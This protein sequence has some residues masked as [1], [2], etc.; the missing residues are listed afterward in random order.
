[1]N[2]SNRR[3]QLNDHRPETTRPRELKIAVISLVREPQL[4]GPGFPFTFTYSKSGVP[5]TLLRDTDAKISTIEKTTRAGNDEIR[6]EQF[7][8]SSTYRKH[9]QDNRMVPKMQLWI[10]GSKST[11]SGDTVARINY[12][13]KNTNDRNYAGERPNL[14]FKVIGLAALDWETTLVSDMLFSLLL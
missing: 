8:H 11:S 7:N 9:G 10:L 1:M 5:Q 4:A 2:H 14:N 3:I 13:K 12:A 6:N